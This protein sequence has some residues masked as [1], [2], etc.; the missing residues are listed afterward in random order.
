[1]SREAGEVVDG[2]AS[3]SFFD[4]C[5][6]SLAFLDIFGLPGRAV[7]LYRLIS[8][9]KKGSRGK[10][11]FGASR[12]ALGPLRNCPLVLVCVQQAQEAGEGY[13]RP[14]SGC[15]QRGTLRGNNAISGFNNPLLLFTALSHVSLFRRRIRRKLRGRT[16]PGGFRSLCLR[17]SSMEAL[18]AR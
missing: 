13:G 3:T 10:S 5:N 2:G 17:G 15:Q 7:A 16:R 18:P 9:E 4:R 1:M 12:A 11:W 8:A 6:E 14:C